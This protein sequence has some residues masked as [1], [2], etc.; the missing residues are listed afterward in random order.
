MSA[1]APLAN[2][3]FVFESVSAAAA[4]VKCVRFDKSGAC[5]ECAFHQ[6]A[7]AYIYINSTRREKLLWDG[8]HVRVSLSALCAHDAPELASS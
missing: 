5:V 7:H 8:A 6:N 2:L 4:F 1:G 3:R